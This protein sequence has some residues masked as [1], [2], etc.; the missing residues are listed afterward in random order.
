MFLFLLLFGLMQGLPALFF[1]FLL[2]DGFCFVHKDLYCIVLNCSC[3][4]LLLLIFIVGFFRIENII[5]QLLMY[6][7]SLSI[8]INVEIW[9]IYLLLFWGCS[10]SA[11]VKF[12]LFY[13]YMYIYCLYTYAIHKCKYV[14][15]H[16]YI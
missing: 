3:C 7:L 8:Q 2:G 15:I 13:L 10:H 5:M 16:M 11:V 14:Y 6:S 1:M 12:H 4:C 9:N